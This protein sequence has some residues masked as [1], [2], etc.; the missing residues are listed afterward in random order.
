MSVRSEKILELSGI[1]AQYKT[2]DEL[3]K[4]FH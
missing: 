1:V 4:L 2:Q 3:V